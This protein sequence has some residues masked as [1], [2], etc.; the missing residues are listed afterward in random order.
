MVD[1]GNRRTEPVLKLRLRR[2][3]I[4][5][6]PFQRSGFREVQL[7]AEDADVSR[8]HGWSSRA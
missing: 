4:F 7:D 1:L 5:P 3:H 8:R 6:L 2:L